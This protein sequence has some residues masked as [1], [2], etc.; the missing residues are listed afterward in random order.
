MEKLMTTISIQGGFVV[1][2]HIYAPLHHLGEVQ[3][4]S[5]DI[6]DS[7][8]QVVEKGACTI[9]EFSEAFGTARQRIDCCICAS[10][11]SRRPS[12]ESAVIKTLRVR[13]HIIISD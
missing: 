1:N 11:F 13:E 12:M 2:V 10:S 4:E 3:Q 6:V 5:V 9:A 8:A 7:I